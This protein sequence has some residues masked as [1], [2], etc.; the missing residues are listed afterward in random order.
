M[1]SLRHSR[2]FQISRRLVARCALMLLCT[3]GAAFGEIPSGFD[4]ANQLYDQ[5][6]FAEAK[7]AYESL[8]NAH[9]FSANLFHNLGNA[10]YRLGDPA[11]ALVA[12]ERA[13]LLDPSHA[14]AR[15]NLK[16]VQNETGTKHE[17]QIWRD[18]AIPEFGENVFVI[19]AATGTWI[20]L[21]SLVAVCFRRKQKNAGLW[22][23]G[24]AGLLVAGYAAFAVFELERKN[25]VSIVIEKV[26]DCGI[27]VRQM[28]RPHLARRPKSLNPR[29][30][31]Q[32]PHPAW[33][34]HR[35]LEAHLAEAQKSERTG[36][37]LPS[38]PW[39]LRS[40]C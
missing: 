18:R 17:S 36:C 10:D 23:S 40:P 20:A 38:F 5:G 3:S 37:L 9:N 39:S 1:F 34:S 7:Q 25:S 13:I 21:F 12:Y 29:Q 6:K 15:A 16:L 22:L 2:I 27:E 8:V 30:L 35:W 33:L 4:H 26:I 32:W 31:D 11:G 28:A 14:E 19:A 24:A